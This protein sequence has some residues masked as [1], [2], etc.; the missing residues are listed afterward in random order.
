MAG[1]ADRLTVVAAE[2]G[3]TLL[4]GSWLCTVATAEQAPAVTVCAPVV[5]TRWSGGAGF[6]VSTC[7]AAVSGGTEADAV[8]VTLPEA[9]SL[10]EKSALLVPARMT[11][12]D[13]G[14]PVQPEPA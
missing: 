11:I 7:V 10:K 12:D 3:T 14:A 13:T 4:F 8:R 1:A 6:T 5:K 2:T 9:V